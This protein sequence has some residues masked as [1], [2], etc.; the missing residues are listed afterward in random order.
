MAEHKDNS[1]ER[2]K[3]SFSRMKARNKANLEV[4]RWCVDRHIC[5]SRFFFPVTSLLVGALSSDRSVE[6]KAGR[7]VENAK[8]ILLGQAVD[9][10]VSEK[11]EPIYVDGKRFILDSTSEETPMLRFEKEMWKLAQQLDWEPYEDTNMP[12]PDVWKMKDSPHAKCCTSKSKH[13]SNMLPKI[14]LATDDPWKSLLL[15]LF[16]N[17]AKG[18]EVMQDISIDELERALDDK[19]RLWSWRDLNK[20]Q[21]ELPDGVLNV[22]WESLH[23]RSLL[24]DVY[25]NH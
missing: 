13:A 18:V 8:A 19:S 17:L 25:R 23:R 6:D 11:E 1:N 5:P 20:L 9:L 3:Q 4:D 10:A 24:N 7:A 21:D 16:Q 14:D 22:L 15:K 12:E 2:L